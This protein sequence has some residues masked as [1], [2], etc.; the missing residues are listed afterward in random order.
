MAAAQRVASSLEVS[1]SASATY[2]LEF[3]ISPAKP[4][5]SFVEG[6]QSSL[7]SDLLSFRPKGEIF[8]RSLAFARDDVPGPVTLR[9]WPIDLAQGGEFIEPRLGAVKRV[10][11]FGSEILRKPQKFSTII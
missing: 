7:S 4:V 5:L 6:A 3:G 10:R 9:S 1:S 11:V 8:L 2:L